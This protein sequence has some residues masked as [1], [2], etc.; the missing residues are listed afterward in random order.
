MDRAGWNRLYLYHKVLLGV[1]EAA[2]G[3]GNL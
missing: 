1:A 2:I 3:F